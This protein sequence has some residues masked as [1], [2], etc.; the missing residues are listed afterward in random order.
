LG[1]SFPKYLIL[2]RQSFHE[3]LCE[4]R[5][6]L[7]RPSRRVGSDRRAPNELSKFDL[8]TLWWG[9]V[10]TSGPIGGARPGGASHLV[11]PYSTSFRSLGQSGR[12]KRCL[13]ATPSVE[14]PQGN[15]RFDLGC[16]CEQMTY[17]PVS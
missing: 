12:L 4:G 2:D 15:V 14:F 7:H 8:V 6:A 1:R 3:V 16:G 5:V 10:L 17:G 9:L 13:L 11:L